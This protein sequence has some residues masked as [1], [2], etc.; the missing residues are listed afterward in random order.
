MIYELWQT[1]IHARNAHCRLAFAMQKYFRQRPELSFSH[2]N[3][4]SKFNTEFDSVVLTSDALLILGVVG[5]VSYF[6]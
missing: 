4:K 2:F 6:R 3:P 1:L 5:N